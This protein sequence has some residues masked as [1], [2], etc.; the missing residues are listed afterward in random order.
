MRNV[1]DNE[2]LVGYNLISVVARTAK[3]DKDKEALQT[4]LALEARLASEASD[5]Y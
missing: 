4:A 3:I 5:C 1:F 2:A